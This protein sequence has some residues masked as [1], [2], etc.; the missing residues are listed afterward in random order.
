MSLGPPDPQST[1]LRRQSR[2]LGQEGT[3]LWPMAGA[4]LVPSL[5][6]SGSVAGSTASHIHQIVTHHLWKSE[7][8]I[9]QGASLY[10]VNSW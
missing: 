2:A 7:V 4:L 1:A 10:K 5:Q 6:E 8:A 9:S 3:P